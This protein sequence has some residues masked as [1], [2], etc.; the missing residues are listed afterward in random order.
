[1]GR[2]SLCPSVM[3]LQTHLMAQCNLQPQAHW[4]ISHKMQLHHHT[5][6]M[7]LNLQKQFK[8]TFKMQKKNA[9]SIVI[10]K[11]LLWCKTQTAAISNRRCSSPFNQ[12]PCNPRAQ[13]TGHPLCWPLLCYSQD[14]TLILRIRLTFKSSSPSCLPCLPAEALAS[15]T[16]GAMAYG[17]Q[18]STTMTTEANSQKEK[19]KLQKNRRKRRLSFFKWRFW[20]GIRSWMHLEGKPVALQSALVRV[21]YDPQ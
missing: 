18:H 2:K 14:R 20:R 9:K 3:H 1:M 11:N 5:Q 4:Q 10:P 19:P 17:H 21:W 16:G 7:H 15:I 13:E 12:K 6:Q 8:I